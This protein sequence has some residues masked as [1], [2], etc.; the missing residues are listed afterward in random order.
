[1]FDPGPALTDPACRHHDPEIWFKS[2][3]EQRAVAIAI[4]DTCPA[5]IDCRDWAMKS[6]TPLVGVWG[7]TVETD[8]ESSKRRRTKTHCKNGHELPEGGGRC[9]PCHHDHQK[10]YLRKLRNRGGK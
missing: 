8:R 5:L 6:K 7:G 1:V 3:R 2:G 4:C 10:A 9:R